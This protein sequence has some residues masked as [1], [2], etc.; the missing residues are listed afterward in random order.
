LEIHKLEVL[1]NDVKNENDTNLDNSD[2]K[3]IL[4]KNDIRLQLYKNSYSKNNFKNTIARAY[5]SNANYEQ[6]RKEFEK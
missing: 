2:S 3:K 4:L 1:L 5:E 6:F